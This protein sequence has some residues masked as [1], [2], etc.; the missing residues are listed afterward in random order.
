LRHWPLQKFSIIS[1]V[2]DF[3]VYQKCLVDSLYRFEN[4]NIYEL[5]PIDNSTGVYSAAQALN[6]GMKLS[7]SDYVICCHQDVSLLPGFFDRASRSIND[8]G[9]TWGVIGC[10]GPSMEM[11]ID[12]RPYP[13]G[14]VYG[15]LPSQ[16]DDDFDEKLTRLYDGNTNLTEV[17]SVDECLFMINKRHNIEFNSV[18]DGFHFYG[19]DLCLSM[20]SAG[21]KVFASYLPIIHHGEFSTSLKDGDVGYWRLYKKFIK[22]WSRKLKERFFGTHMHWIKTKNVNKDLDSTDISTYIIKNAVGRHFSAKI[23]YYTINENTT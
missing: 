10:A 17:F 22:L 23:L 20:K 12:D 13:V 5:I 16:F 4:N 14:R 6:L 1:C 15:G 8:A 19:A 2:S 7:K 21:H 9:D 11:D 18:L 3:E